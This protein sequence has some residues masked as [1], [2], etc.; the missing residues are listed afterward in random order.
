[1]INGKLRDSLGQFFAWASSGLAIS[2][3]LGIIV[4]LFVKGHAQLSLDFLLTEPTASLQ[5]GT[6]GGISTPLIGTLL[7]AVLGMALAFPWAL[8]TAVYLAEY[9]GKN[10]AVG[11]LRLG[12]D[13]LAGVPTIVIAI[14]GVAIFTIPQLG[15]L[16]SMVEGVEGTNRAFGRSFLVAAITMAVMILPF[17]IK[18]CEEAIKAVPH[19]YREGSLALGAT[20]WHTVSHIV[21]PSA[22]GGIITGVILGMGR[23][24]GDTAIVWLTLG[25]TMRMTGIQPWWQPV[26]WI[27]TLQNT[28]STLTSYIYYTSPAGEGNMPEK[29]FGASFVL[30]ILI[31]VL[32]LLTDFFGNYK[33]KVKED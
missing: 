3:C 10:M 7:L 25:G 18:V 28:G 12:I 1:M 13:V 26:N 8:A 31:V 24:I 22:R 33:N 32:N 23:I 21:L 9:A 6:S 29:A 4:Y 14:F 5:D 19:S 17:V 20:K 30:I 2:V 16:S 15:F 27:S 11:L